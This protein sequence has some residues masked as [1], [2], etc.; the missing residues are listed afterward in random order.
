MSERRRCTI[1]AW[2]YGE[3]PE[4]WEIDAVF[5]SP[6][7]VETLWRSIH[8]ED[9]SLRVIAERDAL[10]KPG[11]DDLDTL[12]CLRSSKPRSYGW[13]RDVRTGLWVAPDQPIRAPTRT[14]SW[15]V[16][17][18]CSFV[19]MGAGWIKLILAASQHRLS[20]RARH[21]PVHAEVWLSSIF[22]PVRELLRWMEQVLRGEHPRMAIDEEGVHV[23]FH[24]LPVHR[25]QESD[26][27]D[28]NV[29]ERPDD[30]EARACIRLLVLRD[31]DASPRILL[32]AV[33][34]RRVLVRSMYRAFLHAQASYPVEMS[35]WPYKGLACDRSGPLFV[36]ARALD[37]VLDLGS[38]DN[39]RFTRG[40]SASS[41]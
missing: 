7:E 14:P 30:V 22:D 32:D 10:V 40:G 15:S 31:S 11:A 27:T 6:A 39:Q 37:E 18:A 23:E 26:G 33:L 5:L 8:T 21:D 17:L 2:R 9:I 41:C 4:P 36:E 24:A 35:R 12:D 3:D 19:P 28:A 29:E 34:S 25:A 20:D 16:D 1:F 38:M 13:W